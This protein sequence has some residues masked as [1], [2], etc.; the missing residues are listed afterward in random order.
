VRQPP[1]PAVDG[2]PVAWRARASARARALTA[3]VV[4]RRVVLLVGLLAALPVVVAVVRALTWHWFPVSIDNGVIGARS[5]DV[6]SDRSP[7][8][9]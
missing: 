2:A 8:V 5:V 9:G 6:F 7:L 3:W 1:A 4:E